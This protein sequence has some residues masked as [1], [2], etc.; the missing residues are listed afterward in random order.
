MQQEKVL[1][2]APGTDSTA[3][4]L[5]SLKAVFDQDFSAAVIDMQLAAKGDSSLEPM[6]L[7]Q[8]HH[9]H[10]LCTFGILSRHAPQVRNLAPF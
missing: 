1:G 8:N 9:L 3:K 6:D 5:R 7:E 4:Y 10:L 2:E